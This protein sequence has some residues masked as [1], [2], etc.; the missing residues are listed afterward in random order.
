MLATKLYVPR[1]PPGFVSRP[2]LVGLLGSGL[3][4]ELTLVC[5]PAGFGKTSLLADWSRRREQPVGWLSLDAGDR[6]PV[7]FWR[8][9]AAALDRVRP[10]IAA[11]VA[12]L[13]GASAPVSIES[14]VTE[15]INELAAE[16]GD[17]VLVL[18]DYHL[19]DAPPVHAS[20]EFL[21]RHQPPGLHVVLAS[22]TDPP[23]SLAR[24]RARGQLTELRADGLR[25]TGEEAADL[26]REAAGPDVHARLGDDAV[27]VLADRTEGWA[28]GLQLAAL[29][30]PGEPD[31]AAFVAT[32]SGSH[33]YVLDYLT[34][35]VLRQQPEPVREFLLQTS[36]LDRLS[37]PLCDAV[38]G[39]TDSQAML[40]TIERANLF[41]SPLDDVRGWWRYHHLF[42]DLLRARLQQRPERQRELHRGAAAWHEAHS[43]A[44]GSVDEA[45]RHALAAGDAT[46]VVRLVER[47]FDELM[48]R[49]EVATVQRWFAALPAEL[50][51]SRP[52]LLLAQVHFAQFTGRMDEAEGLLDAAERAW[53][54]V[55]DEPYEPTVGKA[56]SLL[57][58]VP[59]AIALSRVFAA[60]GRGD[61]EHTSALA[62]MALAR[63]DEGELALRTFALGGLA[64]ADW[65]RGRVDEAERELVSQIAAFQALDKLA[66][67]A[68]F[69]GF[70]GQAQCSRGDLDAAADTYQQA[71]ETTGVSGRPTP[72]AGVGHVG[73]AEVAYQRDDIDAASRHLAVGL[74]LCRRL[75]YTQ[76]LARGLTTLAWT[77]HVQAAQAAS[78]EAVEEAAA[79][80]PGP[81]LSDL[82]NPVPAQRARLLLAQ[83]DVDTAARWAA[84]RG[85]DADD[86]PSY[87][88]EPAYMVLARVLLAKGRPDQALRLLDRL[89]SAATVQN[90]IGSAIEIQA[91]RALA[92]AAESRE[93]D[94]LNALTDAL[95][96]AHPQGYIR[97][98]ADEGP[99]MAALFGR[100]IAAHR[101]EPVNSVPV[102]YL[103]R[104]VRAFQNDVAVVA[105]EAEARTKGTPGQVTALS[106]REIEVLR[107]LA[108]GKRNQQIADQLY[109]SVNTV[110]K[111]VTHILEK[112]GAANRT[113]ATARA[114]ELGL[115]P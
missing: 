42:A 2:R 3:A 98:F 107:L 59:A 71:L 100:L 96:L 108:A 23:L 20:L 99:P 13:L 8:H 87:P 51:G 15:L 67:A 85:I 7:R 41:L 94:A 34:E 54:E 57:M 102:G 84:E 69:C 24:W 4:R 19:I 6:D 60:F 56:A 30:L 29:S 80:A 109:V 22:R 81:A 28:A 62:S 64:L 11:W 45:V 115:V 77:R 103:G 72:A 78:R 91:L 37:G 26:L 79:A 25:F 31:L 90:R 104:L 12:P 65:L 50:T 101:T 18:D 55:A 32:F 40:E 113:E 1:L 76:S 112:L 33:R 88:Q 43:A 38:T 82:F 27:A 68:W 58:N 16:P 89:H 36:V 92:L 52:R 35:E 97:V 111:H 10:G 39:R 48:L 9:V 95:R 53:P 66:E 17:V 5:A 93:S 14:A 74:P 61:A 86:E 110:K 105:S 70:L 21:L 83:G 114:R 106:D 49:S 63:L 73:L 46:W 44:G 47:H 75:A